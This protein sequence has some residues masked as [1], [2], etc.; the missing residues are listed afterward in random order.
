MSETG[1][2]YRVVENTPPILCQYTITITPKRIA[3]KER[4]G[5]SYYDPD[6]FWKRFRKTPTDAWMLFLDEQRAERTQLQET[7]AY[8]ESQIMAGEAY[9]DSISPFK[10]LSMPMPEYGVCFV[11]QGTGNH[12]SEM[13]DGTFSTTI[14]DEC[15]QIVTPFFHIYRN[16]MEAVLEAARAKRGAVT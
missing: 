6:K 2:V 7:L 4:Y 11:C 5:L 13:T 3:V 12:V 1:I 9:F 8:V 10:G 15:R 14:C 16:L